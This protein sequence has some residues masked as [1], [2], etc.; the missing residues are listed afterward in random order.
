NVTTGILQT[1]TTRNFSAGITAGLNLFDG[2]RNVR[3]YQYAKMAKLA[4]EYSLEQ[5]KD[6]VALFVANAYLEV[7]FNKE[8]LKVIQAQN[9]ITRQQLERAEALVEAGSLPKGDLLEI[10]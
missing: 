2:L 7:L 1:Q 4:R 6:D 3:Q 10:R 9:E 5:M 8:N